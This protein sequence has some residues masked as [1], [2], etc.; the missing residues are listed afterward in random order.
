MEVK[1]PLTFGC[2]YHI[3]NRGNNSAPIFFE[4]ENY[5]HFLRLYA[6]YIHPIADTYAWCLLKNHF[7]F[8]IKVKEVNEIDVTK[9]TY[10]KHDKPKLID[11]SRQ[12]S[13]LFNAYTQSINKRYQRT[14][15]LF[16]SRFERKLVD[17]ER[18]FNNLVYYIHHN[19]VH[20]GLTKS[21][22][23][24]PWSSY[25]TI[26][27]EQPTLLNRQAVLEAYGSKAAFVAY[28]EQE[29]DLTGIADWVIE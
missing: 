14:G 19:P 21:P 25:G 4:T 22:L 8:L 1:E 27:S 15:S 23:L 20:H 7:H 24:Y 16:E 10:S 5:Y 11:A 12:F 26:I 13:H 6:K 9:F 17:S 18:Y 28:H 29:Q 3:Y 2:Y